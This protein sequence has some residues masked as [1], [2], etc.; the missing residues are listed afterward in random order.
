MCLPRAPE[1]VKMSPVSHRAGA[2]K[3][4]FLVKRRVLYFLKIIRLLLG[5]RTL[6][7]IIIIITAT[8]RGLVFHDVYPQ[9]AM[10]FNTFKTDL[11]DLNT[12]TL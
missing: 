2:Y 4:F 9:Y 7:Y 3:F 6:F 12:S 10:N 11:N 5:R 1:K 8:L